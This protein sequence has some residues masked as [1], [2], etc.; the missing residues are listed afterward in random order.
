MSLIHRS[1]LQLVRPLTYSSIKP[2]T[3]LATPIS[4]LSNK[5]RSPFHTRPFSNT[6]PSPAKK[7]SS[8]RGSS[9]PSSTDDPSSQK[10]SFD[11]SRIEK[12]MGTGVGRL[13]M[14]IKTLVNRVGRLT[15]AYLDGVKVE[16]EG[17]LRSPIDNIAQVIVLDPATLSV[18]PYDAS[19]QKPIEKALYDSPELKLAPNLQSDGSILLAVP[20]MTVESRQTLAKKAG[21]VCEQAR[22]VIRQARQVAQKASRKDLDSNLITKDDFKSN[23]KVLDDITKVHTKQIDEIETKAKRVLLDL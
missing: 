14:E 21:Q 23:N 22:G 10:E 17:G 15:P 1:V 8:S 4:L 18:V 7:T 20:K 2:F 9:G 12:E 6:R 16:L 19:H 13:R 5:Q 11:A 3:S